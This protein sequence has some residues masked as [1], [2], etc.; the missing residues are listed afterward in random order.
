VNLPWVITTRCGVRQAQG[1]FRIAAIAAGLHSGFAI[2]LHC[3]AEIG[4]RYERSVP[5]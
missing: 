4:R 3:A 5:P 2:D 1:E